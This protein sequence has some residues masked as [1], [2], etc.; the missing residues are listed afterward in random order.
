MTKPEII[1]FG[2]GH[3]WRVIFGRGPYIVDYEEQIL[4]SCIVRG[5]CA[6]YV[7]DICLSV[8]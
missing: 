2:D 3:Y 7:V 6:R 4:L 8:F 5:W 1:L